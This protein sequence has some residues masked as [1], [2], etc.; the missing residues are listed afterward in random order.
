[1]ETDSLHDKLFTFTSFYHILIFCSIVHRRYVGT[2]DFDHSQ[3][4]TD[5]EHELTRLKSEFRVRDQPWTLT[6]NDLYRR[7]QD[8]A[9]KTKKE[10]AIMNNITT[11][12]NNKNNNNN[13]SQN[14]VLLCETLSLPC[15]VRASPSPSSYSSNSSSSTTAAT[16][17]AVA[18]VVTRADGNGLSLLC[19]PCQ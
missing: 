8:Y 6:P 3:I 19:A 1:M 15:L 11:T 13:Q 16:A 18:R 2:S 9:Y 4:I 12:N 5:V 10:G 7:Y 14:V 17:V